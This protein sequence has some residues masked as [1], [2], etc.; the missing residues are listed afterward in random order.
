MR[1]LA[2]LE[3]LL[4][5]PDRAA[6][7]PLRTDD[8]ATWWAAHRDLAKDCAAPWEAAVRGGA[9]ADR[10]GFGFAAGYEAALWRLLPDHDRT[11]SAALCATEA[12]GVHPRAMNTRFEGGG[13]DGEKTFVTLGTH[14][15]EL[16][17]LAR[18]GGDDERPALALVRVSAAADGVV[19]TPLPATPFVPEIPHASVRFDG[20]RGERLDGD[21][22]ADHVRPF[23]TIEDI[24]VHA[25]FLAWLVAA[26]RRWGFA[27]E[28]LERALSILL[29]L[30]VLSRADASAPATHLAL[31]GAIDATR[32]V[33]DACDWD[34]APEMDRTRWERDRRLLDV[35]GKAR[36]ARREKARASG[37]SGR[38]A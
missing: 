32:G 37:L 2:V 18:E 13:L 21:G 3:E 24:H 1:P 20:A 29:G 16:L 31:A 6:P 12:G 9:R 28:P 23:R 17:V 14:A 30:E 8:V 11:K 7:E 36:A 27:P 19:L 26:G 5:S 10:L 4:G 33:V 22:W 15:E 35:A 38:R 25:A 34:R